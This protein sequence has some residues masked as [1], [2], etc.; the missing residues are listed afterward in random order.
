M[1]YRLAIPSSLVNRLKTHL[2]QSQLEQGAFLFAQPSMTQ[3][4]IRLEAIDWFAVPPEGWEVQMEVYLEMKDAMRAKIM[5][6]ARSRDLAVVDCHSHPG[7]G[8]AVEF[9]PSDRSGIE[10]FAAYAKWKLHGKPFAAIVWGEASVDAVM[11][12]EDFAKPR[13]VDEVQITNHRSDIWVPR[14][15]WF[16]RRRFFWSR[17]SHG[18]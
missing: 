10:D 17:R 12:C 11:F 2:F 18:R 4:E 1:K 7:S 8:K 14:N 16:P 13:R 5:Q 6:Q 9:S 15:T 3:D